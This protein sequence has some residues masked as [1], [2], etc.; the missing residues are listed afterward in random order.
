MTEFNDTERQAKQ[1]MEA[2]NAALRRLK[3]RKGQKLSDYILTEDAMEIIQVLNQF[4][5]S[6]I[7]SAQPS[8]GPSL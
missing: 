7:Y 1:R 6:S 5:T 3:M 8:V 2:V 4:L